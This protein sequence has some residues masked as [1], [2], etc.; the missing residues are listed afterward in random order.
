METEQTLGFI[1]FLQQAD[2]LA[3][4][5]LVLM[6]LASLIS[7]YL[8]LTKTMHNYLAGRRS[9]RFLEFFWN[10]PSLAVVAAHLEAHQPKDP[11]SQLTYHGVVA[12]CHHKH[13]GV[14]RV[15]EAGSAGDFVTRALRNRIDEETARLESGLT[16]L[17][18]IGSTA[19]FVGL[20]GT[21]W[22]IYHA[23][24]S[25]AESGSGGLDKVAGP[26]GEALIMT[27]IGLAVAIPAVLGY[28]FLVRSNRVMLARLD[29]FAYDLFTFLATG[30]KL[31]GQAQQAK[32]A[33]LRASE[34]AVAG[35]R[36]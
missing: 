2:G 8:I 1:N 30:A 9:R 6:V 27:A 4:A 15:N 7:W 11:F 16:L 36:S 29:R 34:P 23:L 20:L 21:V 32:V 18:S 33:H 26:V 17:A 13:H 12:S 19:P 14:D 35:A 24:I 31:D 5:I 3:S 10:A 22:G 28:N 25:I